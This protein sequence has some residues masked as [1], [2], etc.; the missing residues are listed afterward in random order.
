MK[1]KGA[2]G[3]AGDGGGGGGGGAHGGEDTRT[4]LLERENTTLSVELTFNKERLRAC[5]QERD[6]L[7]RLYA[8]SQETLQSARRDAEDVLEHTKRELTNNASLVKE[9]E[10]SIRSLREQLRRSEDEQ[11]RL[12][13]EQSLLLI[14]S[15]QLDKATAAKDELQEMVCQQDSLIVKQG[16]ELKRVY[17]QLQQEEARNKIISEECVHLRYQAATTTTLQFF[18]KKPCLVTNTKHKCVSARGAAPAGGNANAGGR[19][20][21]LLHATAAAAGLGPGP[22]PGAGG[23]A[24]GGLASADGRPQAGGGR[25]AEQGAGPAGGG[26][27]AP[28]S[29]GPSAAAAGAAGDHV[30]TDREAN[31]IIHLG[32]RHIMYFGG[33]GAAGAPGPGPPGAGGPGAA[34]SAGAVDD[35]SRV[36]VLSLEDFT[37]TCAGTIASNS[38]G[39]GNPLG[40]RSRLGHSAT[41]MS[42]SKVAIIGGRNAAGASSSA[43]SSLGGARARPG[44][45]PGEVLTLNTDTMRWQA[46]RPRYQSVSAAAGSFGGEGS[47]ILSREGHATACL[48]EKVYVFG[49]TSTATGTLLS[50]LCYLDLESMQVGQHFPTTPSVPCPRR[51]ATLSSSELDARWLLVFGGRDAD[52]HAL[53]DVFVFEL[54]KSSWFCPSIGGNLPRARSGHLAEAVGKYLIVHGGH[55]SDGAR[56]NDTWML[57]TDSWEWECVHHIQSLTGTGIGGHA[58]PQAVGQAGVGA[59]AKAGAHHLGDAR[60]VGHQAANPGGLKRAAGYAKANAAV[61]GAHKAN[62]QYATLSGNRLFILRPSYEDR[63]EELEVVEFGFPDEM[64]IGGAHPGGGPARRRTSQISTRRASAVMGVAAGA[65]QAGAHHHQYVEHLHI[66][67]EACTTLNSIQVSWEPP[68]KNV[69]RIAS[70][71]LMLATNTGAVREVFHGNVKRYKV[72]NLRANTEYIFCVKAIYADGSHLWSDCKAFRTQ[73]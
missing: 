9:F 35:W 21:S 70:Y 58:H 3:A 8:R 67:D 51:G 26:A 11:A 6:N 62:A 41:P 44:S 59:H 38:D 46:H 63:L 33:R 57:D 68:T 14:K 71:R 53:N 27:A 48:R 7:G 20:T 30:P 17:E 42:K 22:A 1:K 28:S 61:M 15:Q 64:D 5:E 45:H 40:V 56:L 43:P 52:E 18:F 24:H 19:R 2:P 29:S 36:Y 4:G 60:G 69:D 55:A 49:G 37:W 66:R 25:A 72:A 16:E 73:H 34:S 31:S 50:D 54:D 32:H 13:E 23:A 39:S 10:G 47:A 12:R 65:H